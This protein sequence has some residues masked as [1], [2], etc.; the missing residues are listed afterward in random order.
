[1]GLAMENRDYY[2]TFSESYENKRHFGYHR[3]LDDAEFALLKPIIRDRDVL[4]VG[5]GTGLI[6]YRIADLAR[7][8]AGVD[9]SPGMLTKAR[10]RGLEVQEADASELPF[11]DA[12]F[13]VVC[14]FKVLAHV[15]AIAKTLREMARVTR[16]GGKIVAEFYNRHSLRTLVKRLKPGTKI[17]KNGGTTDDDVYTRYDT[18]GELKQIL[19]PTLTLDRVSGIRIASPLALPFDLP[20]FGRAWAGIERG[21]ALTP[22]KRFGGFLVLHLTRTAG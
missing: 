19:P 5:C 12:T 13:D 1:M 7:R 20:V 15:E 4:E 11:E 18:L 10:E 17:G 6:L 22:L 14:S 8:A 16:P 9:L 2:D 21:L 3:F